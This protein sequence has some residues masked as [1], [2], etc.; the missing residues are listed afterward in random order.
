MGRSR[1]GWRR[2]Y[3]RTYSC[4]RSRA[5]KANSPSGRRDSRRE[6]LAKR[7]SVTSGHLSRYPGT[8]RRATNANRSAAIRWRD[9]INET[10]FRCQ[11]PTMNLRPS[12]FAHSVLFFFLFFLLVPIFPRKIDPRVR[13]SLSLL[14]RSFFFPFLSYLVRGIARPNSGAF[15]LMYEV[16]RKARCVHT[17]RERGLGAATIFSFSSRTKKDRDMPQRRVPRSNALA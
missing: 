6:A 8:C 4:V 11:A 12:I 16:N 13:C 7:G 10:V 14:S 15:T 1:G 5:H 2:V 17:S 3:A 9:L